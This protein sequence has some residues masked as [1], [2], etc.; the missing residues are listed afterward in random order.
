M[1]VFRKIRSTNFDQKGGD[2][3]TTMDKG[4]AIIRADSNRIK[5][6]VRPTPEQ[7]KLFDA[8]AGAE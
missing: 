1:G 5:M 3:I 6:K 4:Q 8:S 7:M 2:D